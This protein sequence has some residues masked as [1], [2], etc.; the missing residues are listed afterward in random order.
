MI[1]VNSSENKALSNSIVA[2][3]EEV[4]E[5]AGIQVSSVVETSKAMSEVV[6]GIQNIVQVSSAISSDSKATSK[7][8]KEGYNL[9]ERAIEQMNSIA[10]TSE[11]STE[12]MVKLSEDSQEIGKIIDAIT[13]I[14]SQTNLLA[15]NAAIE[16]ARAGEHGN[17]FSVV[18]D[19]VRKLAEQSAASASQIIHLVEN[20]RL[21]TEQAVRSLN[22]ETKE[23]HSSKRIVD[24][25]G[26]F[27]KDI[28]NA[29]GNV[30]S[31]IQ[32]LT[33]LSEETSAESEEINAFVDQM[34]LLWLN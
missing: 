10:L 5:G 15:L 31:Q 8:A 23:I 33:A 30:S 14:S 13:N 17:G 21:N 16:A 18:A 22:N 24:D 32:E 12:V 7:N 19:E 20:K 6:K 34:S 3:F 28:L 9:L 11:S 2:S 29:T 4:S 27:F 25:A 1:V 26:S